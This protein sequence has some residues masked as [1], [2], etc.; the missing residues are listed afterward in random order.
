MAK[1]FTERAQKTILI[2]Q[3]EAK[4]FNHDYVGTEHILLGLV[5]IEDSASYKVLSSLGV[6]YKRVR[7][8]VEKIVGVGDSIMLLGEIPFT[9][10]AKKVLEYSLEESHILDS[11]YVGT[12]HMLLG[13]IREN[14]GVAARV[15][16]HLGLNTET[17]R[18]TILEL[19]ARRSG[20]SAEE[21]AQESEE[22]EIEFEEAEHTRTDFGAAKKKSKTPLLDEYSRDL[23]ALA[24]ENALDPV[25]G[26]E[27]EIERLVQ[28]LARRTKNNPVLIGEPGVGKTA[29]VEGLAKR[30]AEDE[31]EEVLQGKRI[32]SLDMASVVAGTKYRGEFEQRLKGL[33]KE[34]ENNKDNI[35]FIDELH[36]IIGAGAAEGSIDAS[37]MLKPALAR[38]AVQCIGATT[39][40]EY[41]RNIEADAALERRFQPIIVESPTVEETID[42]IKGLK[43]NYEKH[44][45]VKF[46]EEAIKAAAELSD[47]YI[48]DRALPDKAIDLF[49][50]A[51]ARARLKNSVTP[52]ELKQKQKEYDE[53]ILEKQDAIEKKEFEKAA[54]AKETEERLRRYIDHLKEKWN[55]EKSSN[56]PEVTAE[57]IALVAS[58]WTGIP[59]TKLTQSEAE[60][61]L[62]ME[63][64]LHESIIG[65]EEAVRA[66]SQ[67]IRRS[68]TGLGNPKKPIGG[69]LFLGP[70]GVGKT[71][72]AKTLAEFLFGDE[73]AMVRIDMSEYMEKFAVSRL[74][75]AP[76]GYVG[77]ED[78][79]QLTEAVR[80]RPYSVVVLDE[81]EKAHPDVFNILLQVLDEGSLTDSSGH[82]VSFKNSIVIMTSNVGAREITNKGSSLGFAPKDSEEQVH[83][84]MKSNI[85]E[86][87]KKTF[88]PE[89]INRIDEI[90][91]FH[92][93][94]R[95]D[96]GKILDINLR[97]VTEKLEDRGLKIQLSDSAKN[98]LIDRGYD[99]KYGARPLLRALQRDLEDPLSEDLLKKGYPD[100][101]TILAD[102]DSK[103]DKLFFT[104]CAVPEKV[105]A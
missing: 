43:P 36:T 21:A 100:C 27:D 94:T 12:E 44:H 2:A 5:S 16:E 30:M 103:E 1:R 70:T 104:Q 102:Y 20:L 74:I 45:K 81:I 54:A 92:S 48:T 76:P 46:T 101:T 78:G 83:N 99:P 18:Q 62:N 50:E 75:G 64:S 51:G 40:D 29:I 71:E 58:K 19:A 14:E 52:K 23:T 28:I 8:E 22:E 47:R 42:I 13:I 72:L 93:L 39:F 11:S 17:V 15:L 57:D 79:G 105:E 31:I 56:M 24:K 37:N 3:E 35:I 60:K 53:A 9:P 98:F 89:F 97:V 90:V 65:Q 84:V 85:M 33:I 34:L 69:F 86:E 77:F 87:V 32:L 55:K 67:A 10:R 63:A 6:G 96:L 4:R 38:G 25:I 7:A 59:V 95:D 61:I 88:N 49:D 41:R 82:K 26:R 68:R 80:H 91:V 66:V 73:D